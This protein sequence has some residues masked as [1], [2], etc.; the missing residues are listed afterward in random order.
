M[1]RPIIDLSVSLQAG[2]NSDPPVFHESH[3]K[4]RA[5]RL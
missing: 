2:M 3:G 1:T 4:V 5:E